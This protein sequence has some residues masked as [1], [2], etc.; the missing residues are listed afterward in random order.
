MLHLEEQRVV[1]VLGVGRGEAVLV[2]YGDVDLVSGQNVA[3]SAELLDLLLEHLLQSLVLHL[4]ALHLLTQ[5]CHGTHS[6][7]SFIISVL[8]NIRTSALPRLALP[9][10]GH[11]LITPCTV[12]LRRISTLHFSLQRKTQADDFP[13]ENVLV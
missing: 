13:K 7:G 2:L 3:G 9:S 5:I 4:S 11:A 1:H 8:T 12:L 6:T 10:L